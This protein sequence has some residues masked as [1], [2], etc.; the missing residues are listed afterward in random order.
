MTNP[1]ESA[2]A[3]APATEEGA[4]EEAA[5]RLEDYLGLTPDTESVRDFI[6]GPGIVRLGRFFDPALLEEALDEALA[7]GG[8]RGEAVKA[9]SL[10]RI[11]G[12][13]DS[14]R[15][16]NLRGPLLDAGRPLG[17]RKSQREEGGG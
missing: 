11:P 7:I 5:R 2:P 17:G 14:Q 3:A 6:P 10:T 9:I 8:W 4:V 13:P 12:D 16:N 1:A 15:G